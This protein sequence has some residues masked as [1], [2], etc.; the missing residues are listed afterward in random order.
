MICQCTDRSCGRVIQVTP[1]MLKEVR[2]KF[3][4]APDLIHPE[5]PTGTKG[6]LLSRS[7]GFEI[8]VLA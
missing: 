4:F 2:N 7:W 8:R 1:D 5:C 6:K 3:G